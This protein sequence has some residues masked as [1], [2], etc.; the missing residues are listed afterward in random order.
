MAWLARWLVRLLCTKDIKGQLRPPGSGMGLARYEP[1]G[2]HVGVIA[3]G[4]A[5][6]LYYGKDMV[7]SMSITPRTALDVAWFL[8]WTWWVKATWCGLRSRLFTWALLKAPVSKE[9]WGTAAVYTIV[10]PDATALDPDR[11]V[12]S[13]WRDLIRS[14]QQRIKVKE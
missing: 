13:T 7:S 1:D 12:R 9:P 11:T 8:L 5:V 14:R 10:Q 3:R 2:T 4:D 6:D